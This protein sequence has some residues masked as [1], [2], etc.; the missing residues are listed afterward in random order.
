MFESVVPKLYDTPNI[1]KVFFVGSRINLGEDAS[2]VGGYRMVTENESEF[3]MKIF[4]DGDSLERMQEMVEYAENTVQE[5]ENMLG[6][7]GQDMDGLSEDDSIF[8]KKVVL[9]KMSRTNFKLTKSDKRNERPFVKIK[10]KKNTEKTPRN[11]MN[12]Y[13]VSANTIERKEI[14]IAELRQMGMGYMEAVL[15]IEM[16]LY[17]KK[18]DNSWGVIF[19]AKTA[20]LFCKDF[21]IHLPSDITSS[22]DTGVINHARL[23][24]DIDIKKV[25]MDSKDIFKI[26]QIHMLPLR[27]DD[28]KLSFQISRPDFSFVDSV[29]QKTAYDDIILEISLDKFEELAI[30]LTNLQSRVMSLVDQLDNPEFEKVTKQNL[31]D[32][33]HNI[34]NEYNNTCRV[35]IPKKLHY[36]N[37][38][39]DSNFHPKRIKKVASDNTIENLPYIELDKLLTE[40][41]SMS[42]KSSVIIEPLFW[43]KVS[44]NEAISWGLSMRCTHLVISQDPKDEDEDLEHDAKK[45]KT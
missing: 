13:Y 1:K 20:D 18:V 40:I 22:T 33:V 28:A 19:E 39:T 30:I 23:I 25:V 10:F 21:G 8:E 24:S 27:L 7:F 43:M 34:L 11:L 15:A 17:I 3:I 29:V 35:K 2:K 14:S 12:K 4:L 45:Q 44:E 6:W 32:G 36:G 42:V 31:I 38:N 5:N 9:R 26:G 16:Q 37:P 41:N